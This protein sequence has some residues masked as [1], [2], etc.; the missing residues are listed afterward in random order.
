MAALEKNA[1]LNSLASI[2]GLAKNKNFLLSL[3]K[4]NNNIE[5]FNLIEQYSE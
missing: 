3:E 4:I 5:L 1:H 2:L